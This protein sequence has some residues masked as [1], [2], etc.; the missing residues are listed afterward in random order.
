MPYLI[1]VP[2]TTMER[3]MKQRDIDFSDIVILD[4]DNKS[5][6]SPFNDIEQLPYE[7]VSLREKFR[8]IFKKCEWVA[9]R[10]IAVK[11]VKSKIVDTCFNLSL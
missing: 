11:A 9:N 8:I 10:K 2:T 4:L 7:V 1:G 3:A 6:R 5:F